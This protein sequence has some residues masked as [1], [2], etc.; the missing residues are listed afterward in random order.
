LKKFNHTDS[1]FIFN[2]CVPCP[3]PEPAC[4]QQNLPAIHRVTAWITHKEKNE[5]IQ[6][7]RVYMRLFFGIYYI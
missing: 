5:E 7:I 1:P 4:R 2:A 3:P 6:A